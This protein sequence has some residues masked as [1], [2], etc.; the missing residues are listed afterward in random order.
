[1]TYSE[2]IK[3][4]FNYFTVA[5]D[6]WGILLLFVITI[7]LAF[8]PDKNKS[9]RQLFM[10]YTQMLLFL[11]S[12]LII[13]VFDDNYSSPDFLI[14]Y[15]IILFCYFML[16]PMMIMAI[17]SLLRSSVRKEL[18]S[19]KNEFLF[20]I[21]CLMMTAATALLIY[22][23]FH[24]IYYTI[25]EKNNY[26]FSPFFITH[27]L[28]CFATLFI[29]L[30]LGF[31]DKNKRQRY[32]FFCG[33]VYSLMGLLGGIF[34]L[35][36]GVLG[37]VNVFISLGAIITFISYEKNEVEIKMENRQEIDRMKTNLMMSQIQPHFLYN[38]LT[39]I[40]Y[41]SDKDP[42]KTKQALIYFS[43][44]LRT[45]LE[46]IDND[47]VIP[48][49]QELEHTLAYLSLEKLRFGDD[50][51]I[52]KE[53]DDLDFDIPVLCMQPLVENAVKHGIHKS[54]SGSGVII[55]SAKEEGG[56]HKISVKDNGVGFDTGIL[57]TLGENHVGIRNVRKRLTKDAGAELT[58]NSAPG[59]GTECIIL[60]PKEVKDDENDGHRR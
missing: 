54:E 25:D 1:M 45:N 20:Y 24:N 53:I 7:V 19:R 11:Y 43:K 12:Y 39:S 41:I 32:L 21:G 13:K 47:S 16:D 27:Y 59:K 31:K 40:I 56:F 30:Y 18:R 50:L 49:R 9:D 23:I 52:K 14:F 26:I 10:L 34:D 17:M 58:I 15:K 35:I 42:I 48:F 60:I 46:S 2:S 57:N 55:I 28:L 36:F 38:C 22:S 33:F 3:H 5:V 8:K 51:D 29:C 44:Y 4:L 37:F 6:I